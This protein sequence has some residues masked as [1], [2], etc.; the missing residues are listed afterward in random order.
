VAEALKFIEQQR[1]DGK[2][3][4]VVIWYGSPHS[5]WMASTQDQIKGEQANSAHHHGELV[6]MDRSIGT[7]RASLKKFG[8]DQNTL[9]WFCSDN[10]GLKG[11]GHDSVGGLRG[12]KGTIWEGGLRVPGIIEWP[13]H[14]K[15]RVTSYPAST[16]DILPT[17][18]D[19]LGLPGD[20]M[21]ELV[22][23]MSIKPL[24]AGE[25]GPRTK[26]IPFHYQGKAALID[27][28]LKIVTEKIGGGKYL[29]FDLK[30]D[31]TESNDLFAERAVDA[32]RLRVALEA[33]TE[34]V[35]KSRTGADYPEGKVTREGPHGRFWYTIPEYQ[36]FL[37]DWAARPEY[38]NWVNRQSR[39]KKTKQK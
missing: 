2:P 33:M 29:L 3:F 9:V 37:K 13:A 10:G 28:D 20:S 5:P 14:I 23:G 36:P 32:K 30:A 31:K 39:K 19:L 7:L 8:L 15:P 1:N 35:A 17:L 11:V 24:L 22:D 16:M 34:S 26:P 4:F 38:K 27:N 12:N 6:A 18:V 21:L 25:I